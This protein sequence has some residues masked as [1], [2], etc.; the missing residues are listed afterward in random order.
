[1]SR[2][3]SISFI[4]LAYNDAPSLRALT[5]RLDLVLSKCCSQYEIIIVDDGS[6][7]QTQDVCKGL[8]ASF[9]KLK[10]LRHAV[11]LGVGAGFSSGV[12]SAQFEWIGYTD[13]DAQYDPNDILIFQRHLN[14]ADVISGIRE[15][16]ADRFYRKWVS[17][18][19]NTLL[20]ILFGL[21]L[22]D[23][24][25]ALKIYRNDALRRAFPLL[26]KGPFYDA[27]VLLKI[28]AAGYRILEV[29]IHHLPRE[30][31]TP[32]G[33]SFS[34]IKNTIHSMMMS[35]FRI[36]L[37]PGVLPQLIAKFLQIFKWASAFSNKNNQK[38]SQ[39]NQTASVV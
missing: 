3:I 34:S 30:W 31:G 32:G 17:K 24:N 18:F 20:N 8:T 25:S 13:G 19:Y 35:E 36:Y 10:I 22:K 5:E 9:P 14:S 16:R 39:D 11:N 29:P 15:H 28:R 23:V 6:K 7:D 12:H 1:M 26:S 37:A 4:I 33:I 2:N 38:I 21:E 27:E